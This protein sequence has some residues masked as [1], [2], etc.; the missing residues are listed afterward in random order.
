MQQVH[1]SKNNQARKT[2]HKQGV[3]MGKCQMGWGWGAVT[4]QACLFVLQAKGKEQQ[5]NGS[6]TENQGSC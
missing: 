5:K 3:A 6:K 1:K 2:K 4:Y